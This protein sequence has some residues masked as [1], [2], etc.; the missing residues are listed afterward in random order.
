ML[1]FVEALDNR[2]GLLPILADQYQ[3]CRLRC[4][5]TIRDRAVLRRGDGREDFQG[6]HTV[7][8]GY[9]RRFPVERKSPE[10]ERLGQQHAILNEQQP[11]TLT[12]TIGRVNG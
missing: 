12:V 3:R 2:L 10:I 9:A 6:L 4:R 7:D 5:A 11:P 1:G 8:D